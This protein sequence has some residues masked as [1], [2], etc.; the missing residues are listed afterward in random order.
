[1]PEGISRS[2]VLLPLIHKVWPAL[3]PPWNRTT[4]C[5]DSARQSTILPFPSSPHWVPMITMFLLMSHIEKYLAPKYR[6]NRLK[7]YDNSREATATGPLFPS[8]FHFPTHLPPTTH[9]PPTTSP[10]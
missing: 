10:P 6:A 3:W 2:M 7:P 8:L 4:P 5:A 9:T 1:M